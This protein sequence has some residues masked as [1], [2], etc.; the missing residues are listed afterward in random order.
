MGRTLEAIISAIHSNVQKGLE[1][2]MNKPYSFEHLNDD[3]DAERGDL[4][5][6]SMRKRVFSAKDFLQNYIVDCLEKSNECPMAYKKPSLH[7]WVPPLMLSL[8]KNCI[9][10]AG[11][12]YTDFANTYAIY[13][14]DVARYHSDRPYGGQ[15]PAIWLNP[16]VS[17]EDE[18]MGILIE[19][20]ILNPEPLT[21]LLIRGVFEKPS[22]VLKFTGEAELYPAPDTVVKNIIYNLSQKYLSFYRGGTQRGPTAAQLAAAQAA[23][24]GSDQEQQQQ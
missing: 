17:K 10:F 1:G 20:W 13:V 9:A 21:K 19:G 4:A 23:N 6:T 3:I 7:F 15:R 11:P 5:L 18:E 16:A 14:D 12:S 8:D 24:A 2:S 22:Q